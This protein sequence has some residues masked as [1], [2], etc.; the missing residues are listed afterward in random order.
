M[1]KEVEIYHPGQ[2]HEPGLQQQHNA[3]AGAEEIIHAVIAIT[4]AEDGPIPKQVQEYQHH[5]ERI[6]DASSVVT[7][8]NQAL[9]AM[10]ATFPDAQHA[11]QWENPFLLKH[12]SAAAIRAFVRQQ[13]EE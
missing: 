2:A 5:G 7:L 4:K 9:T 8:K 10:A 12:L 13:S 3:N 11:A 1:D 6:V